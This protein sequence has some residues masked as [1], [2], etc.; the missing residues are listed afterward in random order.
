LKLTVTATVAV[1]AALT[2][3]AAPSLSAAPA[4]LGCSPAQTRT[5]INRFVTAFNLGDRRAI[6]GA[7]ASKVWFKWYSVTT[8]PGAR[9]PEAAARRDTLLSYFA[10]RH[11]AHERLT[12]TN[13]KLNGVTGGGY[14]NFEFQLMR[15]ADD[16]P[17][18]PTAY[19]GKGASTCST[20]RLIAWVMAA[21]Q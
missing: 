6:N 8:D 15:S 18:G 19:K 1:A 5:L 7:W 14:R 16:L 13:L 10:D 11:A 12:L 20:G 9:T 21:N 3:A 4:K 2:L 17:G